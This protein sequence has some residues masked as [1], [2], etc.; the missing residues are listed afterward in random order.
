MLIVLQHQGVFANIF[1]TA[2]YTA[3]GAR[4]IAGSVILNSDKTKVLLISSVARRDRWIIPK[5]GVEIDEANDYKKAALRETWEEAGAIGK[6][7]TYLGPGTY[8]CPPEFWTGPIDDYN[9]KK[10]TEMETHFYEMEFEKLEDEWPEA[11]KRDR[12]WVSYEEAKMELVTSDRPELSMALEKS[13]IK[14]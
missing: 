7:T 14:R 11:G 6:L 12:K 8:D 9:P 13:S 1:T 4:V 3:T 10:K 5:G 2:V